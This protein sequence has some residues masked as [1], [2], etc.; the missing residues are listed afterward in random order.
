MS[1]L[2]YNTDLYQF[3]LQ[4]KVDKGE[5]YTHTCM[6]RPA[7]SFNIP[8]KQKPRLIE[9]IYDT[10]FNHNIPF[11]LTEKP[12][13]HTIIK[14]DLDFKYPLEG[15]SRTYTLNHVKEIVNLYQ[16]CL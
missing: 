6:G 13:Q 3:L 5:E 11:H 2:K 9:L 15:N 1:S 10:I 4:Y 16:V 7:G 14:A 12:P 8:F